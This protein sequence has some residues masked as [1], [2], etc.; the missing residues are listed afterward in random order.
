LL[1]GSAPSV[2]VEGGADATGARRLVGPRAGG[3]V[4]DEPQANA[5]KAHRRGEGDQ[6]RN[7]SNT[8]EH[9]DGETDETDDQSNVVHFTASATKPIQPLSAGITAVPCRSQRI[10]TLPS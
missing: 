5:Q 6:Q 3:K 10:Q 1:I 8:Q 7:R 9:R 4:V 2:V